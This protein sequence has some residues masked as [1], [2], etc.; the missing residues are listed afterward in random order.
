MSRS[1]LL[2]HTTV[3]IPLAFCLSRFT[4]LAI[5]PIY[6]LC[7]ASEIIKSVIGAI[8]LKKGVWVNNIVGEKAE[9]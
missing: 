4:G 3:S 6:V 8:L 2:I 5:E 7:Q 1:V 9:A